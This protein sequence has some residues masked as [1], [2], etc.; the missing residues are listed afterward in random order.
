VPGF[1]DRMG[2]EISGSSGHNQN[3]S[4]EVIRQKAGGL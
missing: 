1:V 4:P 2:E 3:A